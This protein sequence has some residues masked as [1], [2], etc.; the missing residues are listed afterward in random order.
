MQSDMPFKQTLSGHAAFAPAPFGDGANRP[1][2]ALDLDFASDLRPLS[3]GS[4]PQDMRGGSRPFVHYRDGCPQ[5]R[6]GAF[7]F[8]RA[9]S[10]LACLERAAD[11]PRILSSAV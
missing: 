1:G 9:A 5:E 3:E 2:W 7:R 8:R 4:V 11:A 10:S 6:L